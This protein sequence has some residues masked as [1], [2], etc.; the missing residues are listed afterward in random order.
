M[1]EKTNGSLV[2]PH[3]QTLSPLSTAPA[4]VNPLR[5]IGLSRCGTVTGTYVRVQ[6]APGNM[7]AG[8]VYSTRCSFYWTYCFFAG[9]RLLY[10][11]Y[12][13][14]NYFS[15]VH[16]SFDIP[17]SSIYQSSLLFRQHNITTTIA[18]MAQPHTNNVLMNLVFCLLALSAA[19][20]VKASARLRGRHFDALEAIVRNPEIDAAIRGKTLKELGIEQSSNANIEDD[21]SRRKTQDDDTTT[22]RY[23]SVRIELHPIPPLV[24]G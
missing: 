10:I 3:R 4:A 15:S 18:T 13:L 7:R 12:D 1:G 20:A 9:T 6:V 11:F 23:F 5:Q 8:V 16:T 14:I 22:F 17:A 19:T 21:Q 2:E 24:T